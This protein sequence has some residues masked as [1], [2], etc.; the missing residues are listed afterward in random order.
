LAAGAEKDFD[1]PEPASYL[2]SMRTVHVVGLALFLSLVGHGVA[3]AARARPT[4][5]VLYFDYSG[6]DEEMGFL[7]K[8][9]TQMLVSDLFCVPAIEVVERT[10]LEEVLAELK[11]NQ[12][13]MIDKKS[14]VSIGKLLGAHYLVMGGYFDM[15]KTLRVDARVIDVETGTVLFSVGA[16]RK[17]EDFMALERQLG[18]EL[19]GFLGKKLIEHHAKKSSGSGSVKPKPRV[20]K[21]GRAGAASPNKKLGKLHAR[22]AARYGRALDQIDRG[23]TKKARKELQRLVREEPDF[24]MAAIDLKALA[25]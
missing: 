19:G 18:K 22:A 9:L 4:V 25:K 20:K 11:L 17:V 15:K 16:S 3:E 6:S 1:Q 10:R 7:R 8:G 12:S 24:G 23:D 5:A 2:R 13:K 14:A 21:T